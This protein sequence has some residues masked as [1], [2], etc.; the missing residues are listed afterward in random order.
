[1]TTHDSGPLSLKPPNPEKVCD[2]TDCDCEIIS[3]APE[4]ELQVKWDYPRR[5]NPRW[6]TVTR[7]GLIVGRGQNQRVVPP[8]E[9]YRLA[10]LG[11]TIDEIS[12]WFM[13]KPD[14]LSYNFAEY[15]AKGRAELKH[16]LRRAQVK[17]ALAGNAT[18][19]IWLGKNILGQMDQPV[20]TD[21][22][23]ALPWTE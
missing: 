14:T 17:T 10:A 5:Q 7:Q 11:C 12:E 16:R 4:Q 23:R 8:D 2:H 22:D 13:V 18:L 6:G 1:M 15:I 21:Q 19:L 20:N 3:E 9:V